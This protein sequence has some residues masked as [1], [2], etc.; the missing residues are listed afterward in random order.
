MFLF[1]GMA[2][3]SLHSS[4]MNQGSTSPRPHNTTP[5]M[6][7]KIS[8]TPHTT[9]PVVP[10]YTPPTTHSYQT[11]DRSH[12]LPSILMPSPSPVPPGVPHIS[13]S[14]SLS[15]GAVPDIV[16]GPSPVPN[17]DTP[18]HLGQPLFHLKS[19]SFEPVKTHNE[20]GV[21]STADLGD[22]LDGHTNGNHHPQIFH[23]TPYHSVN[24]QPASTNTVPP[25]PTHITPSPGL[26][27]APPVCHVSHIPTTT[28]TMTSQPGIPSAAPFPGG[29]GHGVSSHPPPSITP[30]L[31]HFTP[32][33]T[34]PPHVGHTTP[35]PPV[36]NTLPPFPVGHRTPTPTPP[37]QLMLAAP[38][39]G[40]LSTGSTPRCLS[41]EENGV[42][43][44]VSEMSDE[45]GLKATMDALNDVIQKCHLKV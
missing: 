31:A 29:L 17:S 44:G 6:H 38:A 23:P 11:H 21:R 1:P 36:T 18:T 12:S 4:P 34:N 8:H 22:H 26:T 42:D 33:I 28:A 2:S 35:P 9:A 30:P 16:K 39:P 27:T 20:S 25:V 13:S 40:S 24:G 5:P 19:H 10:L 32:S 15:T 7:S 45:E 37:T 43:D 14:S 3:L 41:P